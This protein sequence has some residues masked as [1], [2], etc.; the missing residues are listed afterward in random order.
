MKGSYGTKEIGSL[1][2]DFDPDV[3]VLYPS[4]FSGN[5][6]LP[7]TMLPVAAWTGPPVVSA[8]SPTVVFFAN[9]RPKALALRKRLMEFRPSLPEIVRAKFYRLPGE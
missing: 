1:I 9:S 2:H 6:A 5:K 3:A 8:A 7:P 4:W